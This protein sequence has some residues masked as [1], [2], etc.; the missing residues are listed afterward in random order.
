MEEE[1]K[2]QIMYKIMAGNT[3][4][5]NRVDYKSHTFYKI[6]VSKD[7]MDESKT[8]AYKIIS[9][10]DDVDIPDG[11]KIKIRDGYESFYMKDKF[12]AIFTVVVKEFDIVNETT[13]EE[14]RDAVADYT[15]SLEDEMDVPF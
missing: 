10:V 5:V 6:P 9:F 11:T 14:Y 12:N 4:T 7:N 3:Y 8:E 15:K 13:A 2:K 1:N